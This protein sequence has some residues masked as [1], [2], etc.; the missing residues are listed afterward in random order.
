VGIATKF[1]RVRVPIPFCG[2]AAG[3]CA[4]LQLVAVT[5][6]HMPHANAAATTFPR[7][8]SEPAVPI[9]AVMFLS[10]LVIGM[11]RPILLLQVHDDLGFGPSIVGL[12]AGAQFVVA[13][14][15]R[16]WASRL[17][18]SRGSKLR[19]DPRIS[20][21]NCLRYVLSGFARFPRSPGYVCCD[22]LGRM[23]SVAGLGAVLVMSAVASLAA[24][25]IGS[26]VSKTATV[27]PC[28]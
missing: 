13:L 12:V 25:P 19:V 24:V 20:R 2:R 4:F 18:D 28:Y 3:R 27:R 11:V 1:R 22:S 16:L 9:M 8:S 6:E 5:G 7:E 10:L 26:S 23:A 14:I 21:R 17:A 15:S